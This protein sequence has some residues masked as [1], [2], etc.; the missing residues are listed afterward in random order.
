MENLSRK[1]LRSWKILRKVSEAKKI[2]KPETV[3][4]VT[5]SEEYSPGKR[6]DICQSLRQKEDLGSPP[7]LCYAILRN[8]VPEA[9][10][11]RYFFLSLPSL[12]IFISFLLCFS[13]FS[14]LFRYSFPF[15]P[16]FIRLLLLSNSHFNS[17]FRPLQQLTC[18]SRG[19][20]REFGKKQRKTANII[21]ICVPI[22]PS[23]KG[24]ER[25]WVFEVWISHLV[26]P[27]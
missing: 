13:H 20:L 27:S 23:D 12:P 5:R 25:E 4:S 16:I 26:F 9:R 2:E 19:R 14:M 6:G 11:A 17:L 7:P 10:N 8:W 3:P 21:I 24:W 22:L 1:P 15:L 18:N